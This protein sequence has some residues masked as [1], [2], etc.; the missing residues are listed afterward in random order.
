MQSL[1]FGKSSSLRDGEPISRNI[2]CIWLVRSAARLVLEGMTKQFFFRNDRF[3][4]R[5][6]YTA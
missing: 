5:M 1:R 4:G 3:F 2:A 6:Q